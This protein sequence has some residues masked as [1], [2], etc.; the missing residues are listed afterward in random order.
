MN[1]KH[2]YSLII[3][4]SLLLT[5]CGTTSSE[6]SNPTEN[7]NTETTTEVNKSSS[8]ESTEE[9]INTIYADNENINAFLLE[10]NSQYP[11]SIITS[12]MLTKYY[13]HGTEHDNQVTFLVDNVSIILS[14]ENSFSAKTSI[15]FDNDDP[16]NENAKNL[17]MRFVKVYS[18]ELTEDDLVVLWNE[19]I[20]NGSL[21]DDSK[22][23]IEFQ[24]SKS[25]ANNAID[26]LKITGYIEK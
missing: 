24:L 2:I 26:Y 8:E 17:F 3:A 15:Y 22:N 6:T 21:Y 20:A 12:D 18:P 5:A 13:H 23:N 11:D 25:P 7:F 19:I 10:Y 14:S 9:I 1:K 4:C 16:T